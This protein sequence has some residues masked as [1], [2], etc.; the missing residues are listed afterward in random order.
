MRWVLLLAPL[1]ATA[2]AAPAPG[3]DFDAW[4]NASWRASVEIPEGHSRWNARDEIAERTQRQMDALM[5]EVGRAAPGTDARKVADFRAAPPS[6][7]QGLLPLTPLLAR[8]DAVHD[9]AGLA[10]LLGDLVL[11]DVDPVNVGTYDSAHWLGLSVGPGTHG[12]TFNV[13]Y[14]LQGGLGLDSRE[15]YLDAAQSGRL[16]SYGQYLA[17]L[18]ALAGLEHPV[19]RAAAA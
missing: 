9:K 2:G 17:R 16:A 7:S 5:A 15:A 3:D 19:E 10:R 18:L 14:L 11:A 13:V 12:E 4:A 6:E 8:I 1:L